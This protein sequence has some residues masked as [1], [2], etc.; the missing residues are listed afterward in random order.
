MSD[1]PLASG[2]LVGISLNSADLRRE[3][4]KNTTPLMRRVMAQQISE[5]SVKLAV[6]LTVG[7]GSSRGASVVFG[8]QRCSMLHMLP[9]QQQNLCFL[10]VVDEL[11]THSVWSH[12]WLLVKQPFIVIL[13]SPF[14]S[15]DQT[16]KQWLS[17]SGS[18]GSHWMRLSLHASGAVALKHSHSSI[19][20]CWMTDA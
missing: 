7:G 1:E 14:L 15:V 4:A 5:I 3:Y 16:T 20:W 11:S 17:F 13:I 8:S 6:F 12:S 10:S 2:S 19:G 18:D 9:V